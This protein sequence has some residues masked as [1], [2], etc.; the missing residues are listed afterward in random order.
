M[1]AENSTSAPTAQR[2]RRSQCAVAMPPAGVRAANRLIEDVGLTVLPEAGG[3]DRHPCSQAPMD[4][5]RLPQHRGYQRGAICE[6][7]PQPGPASV[8]IDLAHQAPMRAYSIWA[9]AFG[10]ARQ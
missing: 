3:H 6:I 2:C 7:P 5:G 9:T 4:V 1:V 8:P 10:A